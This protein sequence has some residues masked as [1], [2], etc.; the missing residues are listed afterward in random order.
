MPESPVRLESLVTQ[1]L[2]GS[3]GRGQTPKRGPRRR[4]FQRFLCIH[5]AS[6][7]GSVGRVASDPPKNPRVGRS[8]E[9]STILALI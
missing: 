9:I 3:L 6:Q 2:L 1:A 4:E 8:V 5:P 7:K